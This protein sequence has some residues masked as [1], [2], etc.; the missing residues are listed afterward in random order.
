MSDQQARL[1]LIINGDSRN[2]QRALQGLGQGLGGAKGA[3]ATLG[4][5][6]KGLIASLTVVG[7]RAAFRSVVNG[8]VDATM[9]VD[10]LQRMVGLSAQ[11][12]S[13]LRA[14]AQLLGVEFNTLQGAIQ[15]M[16]GNFQSLNSADNPFRM[17][18]IRVVDGSGHL[19][20]FGEILD[21]T[22]EKLQ[23]VGQ[24]GAREMF[25]Q[26]IF[27]G[28]TPELLRMI[29]AGSEGLKKAM[30]QARATGLVITPE[31][32][33]QA[34]RYRVASRQL[35]QVWESMKLQIGSQLLPWLT[36][37]FQTFSQGAQRILPLLRDALIPVVQWFQRL[38]NVVSSVWGVIASLYRVFMDTT[39]AGQRLQN[40]GKGLREVF[41][42]FSNSLKDLAE[43]FNKLK[44]RIQQGDVAGALQ[45]FWDKVKEQAAR[46]TELAATF[47]DD[48]LPAWG[49]AIGTFF[50][51]LADKL[52]S[53]ETTATVAQATENFGRNFGELMT[54][55]LIGAGEFFREA[56]PGLI[57]AIAGLLW[58]VLAGLGG[59]LIGFA[60]GIVKAIVEH[61]GFKS[62]DWDSLQNSL[63]E[64][65]AGK[66]EWFQTLGTEIAKTIATVWGW[67]PEAWADIRESLSTWWTN[68]LEWFTT[69]GQTIRDTLSGP[70]QWDSKAWA[71]IKESLSMWWTATLEWFT[72][73]GQ[74]IRDTLSGPWQ[75]EPDVWGSIKVSLSTWWDGVR[76]WFSSVGRAM[77]N[78]LIDPLVS[79]INR[80]IDRLNS[81]ISLLNRIPGVEL[82]SIPSVPSPSPSQPSDPRDTGEW[83][84]PPVPPGFD[85]PGQTPGGG[86]WGGGGSGGGGGG[87]ASGTIRMMANGGVYLPRPGGQDVHAKVAEKGVPEAF[88]PLDPALFRRLGLSGGGGAVTVIMPVI[89]EGREIAR[90]TKQFIWDDLKMQGQFVF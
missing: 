19:R 41:A 37:L 74:E 54:K 44:A 34:N 43:W 76:E 57:R 65:W 85:P 90:Y 46:G 42:R 21:E 40:M 47:F 15:G 18:G 20:D 16:I 69:T 59:F 10:R 79:G 27:G 28:A 11:R 5:A 89:L 86:S 8:A 32:I 39:A 78:A 6:F 82:P 22:L 33:E 7:V 77:S 1:Q 17:L 45:E 75:W 60:E 23:R 38:W 62:E 87:G 70:W 2:A 64:W 81:L 24:T 52:S 12:A 25:A 72:S 48:V 50:D 80:A 29:D 31:Q 84:G 71:S 73:T 61:L 83:H 14:G 30:E 9:E 63:A 67:D 51:K 58:Q 13:E 26:K 49:K 68:T 55:A 3:V 53:P 66:R 56:A 88:L 35:G 36:R 4:T